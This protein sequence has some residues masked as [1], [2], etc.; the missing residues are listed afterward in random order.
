LQHHLYNAAHVYWY[1]AICTLVYT[2]HFIATPVLA[3][4][5]WL[6]DRTLWLRYISRVILL[7]LAGLITYCLF[8]E[9]PPWMA[10]RDGLSEPV[11]R[12]SPRGWL[13]LHVD[14]LN[15]V[16]AK[17]QD[18]GSNAV[19]AMPSLHFAFAVLVAITIGKRLRARWRLLLALY[20]AAMG[21]TLVYSGEHYVID[22]VA[23]LGYALAAHYAVS[24]W[25]RRRAARSACTRV[26]L[27]VDD[28]DQREPLALH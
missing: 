15:D 19:A 28:A 11:G 8:P 17:A 26:D 24:A 27:A 12:L 10:A 23:G 1:D 16:L 13:W 6:R 2:S 9:A 18:V 22:L 3:A 25:E 5:L 14:S 21:F 7:S 4:I 20:P